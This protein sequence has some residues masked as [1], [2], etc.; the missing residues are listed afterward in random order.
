[1][2]PMGVLRM[3]VRSAADSKETE[4]LKKKLGFYF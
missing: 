2:A 3:V 1:M 4:F